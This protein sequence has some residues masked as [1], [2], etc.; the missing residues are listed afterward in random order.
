MII[1]SFAVCALAGFFVALIVEIDSVAGYGMTDNLGY[2][3]PLIEVGVLAEGDTRTASRWSRTLTDVVVKDEISI[4]YERQLD[5]GILTIVD[6]RQRFGAPETPLIPD[7]LGGEP[8][9]SWIAISDG[10]PLAQQDVVNALAPDFDGL[11]LNS[12]PRGLALLGSET[13]VYVSPDVQPMGDGRY[14]FASEQFEDLAAADEF[15][16]ELQHVGVNMVYVDYHAGM[17]SKSTSLLKY[18]SGLYAIVL[19]VFIVTILVAITLVFRSYLEAMRERSLAL[20]ISG[21]SASI[22]RRYLIQTLAV[23][24]GAGL[25]C[26]AIA[27]MYLVYT[28]RGYESSPVFASVLL[29]M[30]GLA[31]AGVIVFL[32]AQSAVKHEVARVARVFP[33]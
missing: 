22:L 4:A 5:T 14:Y 15:V 33:I 20:A 9:A 17:A 30:I 25:I 23:P 32:V 8:E 31:T 1:T 12:V 2:S 18:F 6:L 19:A 3:G 10:V 11:V 26:C 27:S 13:A 28:L 21:A 29:V 7:A 24:L 16:Q